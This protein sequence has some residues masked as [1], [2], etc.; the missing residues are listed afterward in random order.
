MANNVITLE[1]SNYD[2]RIM[3][4]VGRRVTKWASLSFEEDLFEEGV[5]SN[6]AALNNAVKQIISS[7]GI[8]GNQIT[9]SI[10]GLYSLTR[11]ITVPNPEDGVLN[12]QSIIAAASEIMPLSEE[13]LYFSWQKRTTTEGEQ[14]ALVV[15]IPRDILDSQMKALKASGLNPRILDLKT[16]ALARVVNRKQ[17]IILNIEPG[18]FDT[19]IVTDGST[20]IMHTTA[21]DGPALSFDEGAEQ[22][23]TTLNLTIGFFN[24]GHPDF[25]LDPQTPLF[26]TGQ[27]SGNS[28]LTERLQAMTNFTVEPLEPP[29]EYPEHLPVSQYAVNIGLALKGKLLADVL[30]KNDSQLPDINL[31][32]RNY[33]PWKP[34]ARQLYFGFAIIAAIAFLIPFYQATTSAIGKTSELETRYNG[35]NNLLEIRKAEIA[36]REPLQNAVNDFNN[37]VGLGGGITEDIELI[38]DNAEE[39]GIEISSISHRKTVI[40]VQCKSEDYVTFRNFLTALKESGRFSS[41]DPPPEHYPF[42]RE[43]PITLIPAQEQ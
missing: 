5:I 12:R 23:A 42:R 37:V 6:P 4:I 39:L 43:G 32:P 38:R 26:I 34:S 35:I 29:L 28:D 27:M 30:E 9:A 1:I 17:A 25:H 33:E 24:D 14:Q 10:S 21:W 2:I 11:I 40:T 22:L 20:D 8:R 7:S 19:V 36:R 16:M 13:E 41:L 3:E 18:S 31:L 15:G